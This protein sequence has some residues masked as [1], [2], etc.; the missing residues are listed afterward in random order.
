[1]ASALHYKSL[2]I[3]DG[4]LEIGYHHYSTKK[5][6][7]ELVWKTQKFTFDTI[8]VNEQPAQHLK[9]FKS[10]ILK[11]ESSLIGCR[12]IE[13]NLMLTIHS[14]EKI[15]LTIVDEKD[16]NSLQMDA[17][18]K[19]TILGLKKQIQRKSNC[20]WDSDL[21]ELYDKKGYVL[22]EAYKLVDCDL[23]S[24]TLFIKS[25]QKTPPQT[26]QTSYSHPDGL[27]FFS[28]PLPFSDFAQE[29]HLKLNP[30]AS[31]W[32]TV[33]EGL[34][35]EGRCQNSVCLAFNKRVCV[36][37]GIDQ[38]FHM[39]EVCCTACCPLPECNQP[40]TDVDNCILLNCKFSIEGKKEGDTEPFYLRDQ[41]TPA[42]VG[43]SFDSLKTN[44]TW[45]YLKIKT[46][47][48]SPTNTSFSGC[49]LI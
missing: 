46:D 25:N 43:L 16:G 2:S 18:P 10:Q 12:V 13:G 19:L 6:A 35:L 48:K 14:D 47:K 28:A 20:Q 3:Q 38:T 9:G 23:E 8:W 41:Q 33:V 11:E 29:K 1:M 42:D 34:N 7:E 22:S 4:S 44:V 17:H 24:K 21:F 31:A 26:I 5:K 32:R 36:P 30:Q 39:S 40:L 27:E 15:S 49:T 45:K 37:L